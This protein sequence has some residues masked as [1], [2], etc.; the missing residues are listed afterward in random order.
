MA[1][2]TI[3]KNGRQGEKLLPD[4]FFVFVSAANPSKQTQLLS[5]P[6]ETNFASWLVGMINLAA[7]CNPQAPWCTAKLAALWK[8]AHVV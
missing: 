3:Q 1:R 2:N 6:N 7:L 4:P 5:Q 8:F